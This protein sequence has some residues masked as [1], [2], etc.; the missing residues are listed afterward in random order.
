MAAKNPATAT[1]G[2]AIAAA[3][4]LVKGARAEV[5]FGDTVPDVRDEVGDC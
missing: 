1:T 3:G 5:L 4:N 2:P